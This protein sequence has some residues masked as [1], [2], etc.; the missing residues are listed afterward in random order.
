MPGSEM[1][2]VSDL[3]RA[4]RAE[5]AASC[6]A[7]ETRVSA[8]ELEG[9]DALAY[10][11]LGGAGRG[12]QP[13]IVDLGEQAVLAGHPAVAELFKRLGIGG[14]LGLGYLIRNQAPQ[15]VRRRGIECRRERN[16]RVWERYT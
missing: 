3:S 7:S 8:C 9:V 4:A 12:L 11:A 2:M 10:V 16:L 6:S 5:P 14:G 13:E 1:S 15:A